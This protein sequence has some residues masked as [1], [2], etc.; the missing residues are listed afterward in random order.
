MSYAPSQRRS[1]T[2]RQLAALGRIQQRAHTGK[3]HLNHVLRV[4]VGEPDV[5]DEALCLEL[6]QPLGCVQVA[7]DPKV[8]PVGR[9]GVERVMVWLSGQVLGVQVLCIKQGA[10]TDVA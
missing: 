7:L 6:R 3:P 9:A 4:K 10:C 8:L 2:P 5:I 1:D